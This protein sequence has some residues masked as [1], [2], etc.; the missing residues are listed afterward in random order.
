MDEK[1]SKQSIYRLDI[2]DDAINILNEN[3]IKTIGQLCKKTKK[4][5]KNYDLLQ[6]DIKKIEIELQLI[7]LDLRDNV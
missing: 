4:D 6:N 5:L 1:I 2:S 7:G 3:K